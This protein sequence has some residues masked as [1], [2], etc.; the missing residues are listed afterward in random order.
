MSRKSASRCFPAGPVEKSLT[1]P[2]VLIGLDRV[3]QRAELFAPGIGAGVAEVGVAINVLRFD[4]M[5]VEPVVDRSV[6]VV[7]LLGVGRGGM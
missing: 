2:R 1:R 6:L 5:C 4:I 3:D 7:G